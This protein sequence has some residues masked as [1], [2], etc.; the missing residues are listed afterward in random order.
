MNLA[1]IQDPS[2]VEE[3]IEIALPADDGTLYGMGKERE[4]ALLEETL[5]ETAGIPK[6]KTAM[7]FFQVMNL[8]RPWPNL[9]K[10]MLI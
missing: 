7:A 9:T 8:T 6:T 1:R 4:E 2:P 3:E 10:A 5:R